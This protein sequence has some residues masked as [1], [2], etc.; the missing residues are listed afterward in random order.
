MNFH[1]LQYFQDIVDEGSFTRAAEKNFV[2][3]TALSHA[4]SKLEKELGTQLLIRGNG[5]VTVT[6]GGKIF[7]SSCKQI[8]ELHRQTITALE[9]LTLADNKVR[10]GFIDI[11]ECKDYFELQRRLKKKFPM[12]EFEWVDR[13]SVNDDELDIV[14]GYEY[15]T[16]LSVRQRKHVTVNIPTPDIVWL[17]PKDGRYND[18][19]SLSAGELGEGTDIIFLI[20]DRNIG[21]EKC[22]KIVQK[23]FF[24][25]ISGR[26][27][28]V[29]SA[30]ERRTLVECGQ[31]VAIFEKDLFKYDANI[32]REIKIKGG[33][34]LCYNISYKANVEQEIINEVKHFF[35]RV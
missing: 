35:E 24:D 19:D 29:F 13:Y 11:F 8:L 28:F 12:Y 10:I 27:R 26:M 33:F 3:Q 5:A 15:E 2:A 22:K 17:A 23:K 31:G 1:V 30:M 34:P 4:I 16:C 6:E 25:S 21:K 32:C 18:R 14:I 9:E 7:Y 20:R